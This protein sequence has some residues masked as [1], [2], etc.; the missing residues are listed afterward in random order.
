MIVTIPSSK[1]SLV[2]ELNQKNINSLILKIPDNLDSLGATIKILVIG[3][4]VSFLLVFLKIKRKKPR[5]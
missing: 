5:M 4:Y 2:W 3:L 1:K